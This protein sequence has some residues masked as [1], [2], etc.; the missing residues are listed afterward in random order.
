MKKRG[1]AAILLSL[2]ALGIIGCGKEQADA[3]KLD[4][5]NPVSITV[6]HYYNGVQKTAFDE[7][8]TQFNNT[9]GNEKGIYVEGHSQGDVNTLEENVLAAVEKQV[10]SANVPNIFSTY[11]DTAY[12]VDKM[13]YL[14]DISGYMSEDE[15]SE[16]VG[17]YI[18]EGRIGRD[19]E[20]RIFPIA[21]SSEI[22]ML[23]K[24]DWDVFSEATGTELSLLETKEGVVEAARRYYEWTD[25]LT[26]DINGDGKAFYGR[27]AMANL[28]IIGSMELGTEI[29]EVKEQ[30]VTLNIDREVMKSIWDIY[31]VPYVK[32][33][34]GAYGRFRS[35]DVKI[36]KLLAYTGST[37]SSMYFPDQVELESDS[38]PIE[39]M[40]MAPPLFAEGESYSVQQGAGM[41]IS[42]ATPEE[43]YASVLFLKWFTQAENNLLFGCSSGYLP[44]RKEAGCKEMLDKVIEENK[45]DVMGKTY[46]TMVATLERMQDT[47]L[48]TNK[49]FEGGSSARKVLEYHL[50]D[51]AAADREIVVSRLAEGMELEEAAAEFLTDEAFDI[52]YED[53][54]KAL[55]DAVSTGR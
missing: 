37:A 42:K 30:K 44:V 20:L 45:L 51:K 22:F 9:V 41:V 54:C 18:E 14:A 49:A 55:E 53:F 26:P 19:G 50:A 34:F 33:Y 38:Y 16:Y 46:D 31:Y 21:K 28:F 29:F 43:E 24:T 39:Y 3:V 6:W 2:I 17:S 10:G 11:A 5:K 32:G 25:A 36:G 13:G 1:I 12:A 4:A 15:L 7:L 48:Y 27:D 23:N 35:D 47:I 52:W 40:L 8:V